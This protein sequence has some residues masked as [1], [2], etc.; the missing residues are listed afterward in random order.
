[1]GHVV[2]AETPGPLADKAPPGE[3]PRVPANRLLASI[4]SSCARSLGRLRISGWKLA[5]NDA[6]QAL[7]ASAP[8]VATRTGCSR[9]VCDPREP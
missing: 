6:R 3:G 8:L 2:I 1:M 5:I 9:F 4:A 7:P